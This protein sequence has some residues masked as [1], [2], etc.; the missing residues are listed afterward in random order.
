M[1]KWTRFM[2]MRSGGGTKEPPYEF[3]FIE[4]DEEQ[5]K[6]IFYNRFGHNP[7]RVTCTCCGEDYSISSSDSLD[8]LTAYD[9]NCQW[10]GNGYIEAP[11]SGQK[12]WTLEEYLARYDVLVIRDGGIKPKER[13]GAV[14]AYDQ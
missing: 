4:A 10:K 5:A 1:S 12:L 9:R 2:D 7:E 6:V 11:R 8:D 13:E 14:P 3:I